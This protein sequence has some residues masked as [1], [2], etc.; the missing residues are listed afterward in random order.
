MSQKPPPMFSRWESLRI[1][2]TPRM[3]RWLGLVLLA[4]IIPSGADRVL[5]PEPQRI[6]PIPLPVPAQEWTTAEAYDPL[7]WVILGSLPPPDPRQRK[8]PC[9]TTIGEEPIKGACWLRLDVRPPC[10]SGEAWEHDGKC[11]AYALRAEKSPQSGEV[12]R[13]NIASEP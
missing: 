4:V 10:P 5:R 13:V 1:G 2:A 6:G 8:P 3:A 9:R 7:R 11:Y 12:M